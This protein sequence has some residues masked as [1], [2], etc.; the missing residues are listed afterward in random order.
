[1][2]WVET[3]AS[4]DGETVSVNMGRI[5]QVKRSRD[6]KGALE[7]IHWA[8][9]AQGSPPWGSRPSKDHCS[10]WGSCKPCTGVQV[11]SHGVGVWDQYHLFW[12]APSV[13]CN[14]HSNQT[15]ENLLVANRGCAA[16]EGMILRRRSC[17]LTIALLASPQSTLPQPS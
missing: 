8:P 15:Y 9:S 4:F 1:M 14:G 13:P 17:G 5:L 16:G 11:R 12:E 7:D 10:L 2:W 3:E 6:S